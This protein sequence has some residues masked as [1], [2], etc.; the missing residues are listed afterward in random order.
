MAVGHDCNQCI[1]DSCFV[2]F[3]QSKN[4]LKTFSASFS[5]SYFH[6]RFHYKLLRSV[7][8]KKLVMLLTL[9]E[10]TNKS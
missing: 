1:L 4:K 9:L 2:H 6:Q 3:F 8:E 5:M 10:L 7:S